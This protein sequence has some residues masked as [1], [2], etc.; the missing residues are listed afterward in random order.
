MIAIERRDLVLAL[1]EQLH[2]FGMV[3]LTGAH[4]LGELLARIGRAS[5]SLQGHLVLP[6]VP[7]WA[8]PGCSTD[9]SVKRALRQQELS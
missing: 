2:I 6:S 7:E 8:V 1:I 4:P 9:Q 3:L 5:P